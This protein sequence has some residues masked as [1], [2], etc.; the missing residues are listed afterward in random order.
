MSNYA[1]HIHN[2]PVNPSIAAQV[3]GMA[4]RQDFS[5]GA[6]EKVIMPDPGLTAKILR[7]ANSALYARP[8][9]VTR[10]QNAITLLGV[11][12]I[13]NLVILVTGSSLFK[14][15]WESPFYALFWRH[16]LASA[17]L[18]KAFAA[19]TGNPAVAEEAFV[20]GLLH[21]VGQVALFLDDPGRYEGLL[22]RAKDEG[23]RIS[24]LEREAFATDHREIGSEVLKNW[25]FPAV[26]ADAALEH[27]N[28]N[29]TSNHKL[30][31][32]LVSVADFIAS[33]WFLVPENPIP[34]SRLEGALAYLG[35]PAVDV[36]VWQHEHRAVLEADPLYRECQNLITE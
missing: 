23:A 6:L 17:F 13:K 4:E 35:I 20:A 27:G 18:A 31:I 21:N 24:D 25:N 7:I 28:D 12:T 16:S 33:N 2:L 36:E 15:H 11:N 29:I 10:L 34:Y 8:S 5:F 19:R 14:G 26:Y 3:L 32:L 1:R 30:V 9:K 22:A